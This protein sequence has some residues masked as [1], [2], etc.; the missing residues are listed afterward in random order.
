M[1]IFMPLKRILLYGEGNFS[2]TQA[3]CQK[4][5][6][7]TKSQKDLTYEIV[8]TDY[9]SHAND[10]SQ[11]I[12]AN[13]NLLKKLGAETQI[14]VIF[15]GNIDATSQIADKFIKENGPY[16]QII[17][18]FPTPM[19][20][21]GLN[22]EYLFRQVKKNNLLNK[23]G[24]LQ[25]SHW[26]RPDGFYEDCYRL[27]KSQK[28]YGFDLI[29]RK[30][31]H[32]ADWEQLGYK[33][34]IHD[35]QQS[36]FTHLPLTSIFTNKQD[37]NSGMELADSEYDELSDEDLERDAFPIKGVGS[38]VFTSYFSIKLNMKG[39]NE[40][41]WEIQAKK[42]QDDREKYSLTSI[43]KLIETGQFRQADRRLKV[44]FE[45]KTFATLKA[46]TFKLFVDIKSKEFQELI[47]NKIN[48]AYKIATVTKPNQE[49]L[50]NYHQYEWY[51]KLKVLSGV[52][53]PKLND[54][55]V[56]K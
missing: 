51:G 54:K 22:L 9:D 21:T 1:E 47:V 18:N 41:R 13:K 40:H 56:W 55:H 17:C 6:E 29:E 10:L 23:D 25:I 38:S 14:T 49:D 43:S 3:L 36:N 52:I 32:K 37:T 53:I 33:H 50:Q 34:I 16:D 2:F 12:E 48:E 42:V 31:F 46:T 45:A 7:E 39:K 11:I 24:Q 28:K 20:R 30:I 5:A 4:L 27:T 8:A 19:G 44:L 35:G 15:R 26:A